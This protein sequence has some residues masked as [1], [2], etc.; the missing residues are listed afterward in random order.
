MIIVKAPPQKPGAPIRVL[1]VDDSPT[2]LS[3]LA[4]ILARA[5]DIE[6]AGTAR[7]GKEALEMVPRLQPAVICTDY[8]MPVMNGLELTKEIMAH[9]PRPI[10]V[11][12]SSEGVKGNKTKI[13]ELLEAGAVDVCPKPA[14]SSAPRD[15]EEAAREFASRVRVV[16]R[17]M[18]FSKTRIWAE[19]GAASTPAASVSEEPGLPKGSLV[20]MGAS[21]GGPQALD[22]ILRELPGEFPAPIICVQHISE[23]FLAGMVD[24]LAGRCRLK[25]R[26]AASGQ[27]AL[28][29]TVYFPPERRHLEITGSGRFA[30]SSGPPVDGHIPSVTVLFR[31]V[32]AAYGTKAVG[33]LLSGMGRDGAEGL[34]AMAQAGA[35]TIAQDKATSIVFG[36]PK[37]AIELGAA[38]HILPLPALARKIVSLGSRPVQSHPSV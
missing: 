8:H 31:S 25:V 26:I 37:E 7:H 23:G 38:K 17:V 2:S 18:V 1:L 21:T 13:F 30:L 19:S 28:P 16:S 36:M 27:S 10:L 14:W 34:L 11:V 24:W 22:A 4:K 20:A 5:P 33:V 29:G 35:E 6:I 12:S 15:R 3:I 32:A 9:F